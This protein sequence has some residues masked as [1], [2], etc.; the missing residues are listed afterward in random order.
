MKKAPQ[1]DF[2][3]FEAEMLKAWSD[4]KTFEASLKNREGAKRY[5]FYDGPPFANGLPHFGHSLV[6]SIKDSLGRYHT[7][8]GEYV[9]RRN[10]W[11]THG[12]PVEFAI[13]KEFG[14][15]GKKQILELGLAK[16][17]EACRLSVFKYKEEWEEF[18]RR[19]GRWTDTEHAYVTMD[20]DYTESVWWMLK[21]VQNKGLLYRGYKS[22]PYCPRCETPLS[23][24]E[25]NEGY[26]D[27]VPDPSLYVKFKL[28]DE[29]ASLLGW[30]TTP[31]S[32][33][34]NGAVALHPDEK[35][36]YVK[37]EENDE[38]LVLA[39]KRL[40]AL[41]GDNPKV[42]KTVSAK[43]LEGKSYEPLYKLD[44]LKKY[45]GHENLYKVRLNDHVSIEDGTGVLHVA[46]AYGEDD[47]AIGQENGFPVL[48]TVDASGHVKPGMGL[49]AV[50]GKFFK[51]ADRGVVEDL[52]GRGRVYAAETFT[53][54]YP[55]CYRCDTPLLYYAISTWFVKVS[56]I[57]EELQKTAGEINWQPAHIKTGRFGKWLDGARDWAI[58]RNRY[59]GAPMPIWVNTKDENDYLVVESLDELVKLA[60]LEG[61]P[62]DLHRPMIDEVV[63]EKDGKTYKR[64]EEVLDCWFESGSMPVAQQH[65]PF[66][67]KEAFEA[68]YPADYIGEALDQTRLWFYVLHVLNTIA[69]GKPAYKN[70]L[71]NGMVMAADGQKLSKRLKNYPPVEEVFAQ[72]GADTLRFYLLGNDQAL[73]AGYMRFDRDAMRDIQRNVFGTLWNTYSFLTMYAEID[74]WEP[75]KKL[76]EPK[77]ENVLDQWM[78]ARLNEV[79]AE[80]TEA[81]D[82]YALAKA[83]RPLRELV[84]DLSNWYVRRSRRRFW[85]SEDDGDKASAY[86]TLHY[87][88][89]R[90]AQ[91]LA[92]WTPFVA[93]KLW[94]GLTEGMDEAQSVHLSDWPVAANIDSRY[95]T[96]MAFAREVVTE[97]LAARAAAGVKVRQPLA[98]LTYYHTNDLPEGLRDIV[99]EEV[100]VKEL[101]QV[102]RLLPHGLVELDVEI[103]A[104]LKAEGMMRDVVRQVQNARKET[105]LDVS[106]R[107]VLTLETESAEL[108]AAIQAHAETIKAETL[109]VELKTS[110]ASDQVPVKVGGE[111][112]YVGVRKA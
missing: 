57:R 12:L 11:D 18:F 2:P 48:Q 49:D 22:M 43:E 27:D 68:S 112:L 73:G 61:K 46:A 84:D 26:K 63:I 89:A 3:A 101:K 77:S 80:M 82:A 35:Y 32:L 25:V 15:S 99:R 6:T 19:I 96:D 29:D 31:W 88:L 110:G 23:N 5:S 7:M 21:Q 87:V 92:P 91:L 42:L 107:I 108:A 75:G 16:F 55:F 69:F 36:V 52:T 67:N 95:L 65:F 83:L 74:G 59:W 86:A 38:V 79:T 100:N 81:A 98:M 105:G 53:H 47:L 14:V 103:T 104:E 90:I 4:E 8:K 106:D 54:T 72:E 60:G 10:G 28:V 9:E 37:T 71:V 33:S 78:L 93:D 94:R 44:D 70:V 66:E 85:K 17:N 97:G 51:G 39:E 40:D 109:A 20:R 56:A 41:K 45:E 30:T 76:T 58:S 64:V 13:E 62:E 1:A 34:G 111:K 24:F 50:E 102:K